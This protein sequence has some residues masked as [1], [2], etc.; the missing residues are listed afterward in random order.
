VKMKHSYINPRNDRNC[1]PYKTRIESKGRNVAFEKSDFLKFFYYDR[2]G[3]EIWNGHVNEEGLAVEGIPLELKVDKYP[4]K[5]RE[6][7]RREN[8]VFLKVSNGEWI[9]IHEYEIMQ[10]E[11]S[12]IRRDH[13]LLDFVKN[14]FIYVQSERINGHP[15][16]GLNKR[17]PSGLWYPTDIIRFDDYEAKAKAEGVV[18]KL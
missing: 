5:E 6:N 3:K 15:W 17:K 2:T 10:V 11:F 14:G 4:L 7:N 18:I 9:P 8:C 1:A 13:G 16:G 12:K